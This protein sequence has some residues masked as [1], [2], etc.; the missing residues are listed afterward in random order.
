MKQTKRILSTALVATVLASSAG[1]LIGCAPKVDNDEMTL[2]IY[3]ANYGYGYTWVEDAIELFKEQDWVKAKYPELKIPTPSHNSE[4]TY[5]A[6]RITAGSTANTIDLFF[7][8]SSSASSYF[9]ADSSG[10]SYFEELTDVYNS[11][12]PGETGVLYKDKMID[13]YY[14]ELEVEKLDGAKAY[15]SVPWVNGYFGLLYNKDLVESTLGA[16]YQLPR[17]TNELAKM[18]TDIKAASKVPFISAAKVDYWFD[19][20]RV[21]WAQYEGYDNINRYWNGLDVL[22]GRTWENVKQTG[23]LRGMETLESLIGINSGNTHSL[24]TTMEFTTAQS[25]YLLGEAFMMPN[26]D[27][28]E[29]EM[30]ET[31]AE[32]PY[33]YDIRFMRTPIISS[34]IEK[35][36][37]IDNDTKLAFVVQCVDENKDYA[38]TKA[39]YEAA[40]YGTLSETDY[41]KIVEARK[42]TMNVTGHEACIPSYAT[43]KE[44]AKDFLRFLATD[45]ACESMAKTTKGVSAPFEYDMQ[46]KTPDFYNSLSNLHKSRLEIAAKSVNLRSHLTYRMQYL[47]GLGVIHA[48]TGGLEAAFMSQNSDDRKSAQQIYNDD[49]RY[50]EKD[51]GVNW[52]SILVKAGYKKA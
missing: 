25:K 44:P 21:W 37:T 2:E 41:N 23:R 18:A 35:C 50:F 24:A 30:R 16:N 19:I 48:T 28:F 49:I 8:C 11:E 3:V 4:R 17:T 5:T 51:N 36:T 42:V 12:V 38:T 33:N 7:S 10:G 46:T 32:N 39:A 20:F 45:I 40:S 13:A 1:A 9:I 34:I 22:G 14:E 43:A 27:W 31:Q 47:G 52:N 15:Y 6:D 29:N 26:G